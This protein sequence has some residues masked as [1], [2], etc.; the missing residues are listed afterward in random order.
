VVC[1]GNF[2]FVEMK[3]ARF[4][5]ALAMCR[6]EEA[7]MDFLDELLA[8]ELAE[9]DDSAEAIKKSTRRDFDEFDANKDQQL[10]AYEVAGRF[11]GKINPIDLFY[12]FTQADKD[13]SGTVSFPEYEAYV[14]FATG[15]HPE[16]S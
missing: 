15:S 16:E 10:D 3:V 9:A 7:D 1:L 5:L 2:F 13:L 11:G 4:V 14:E 6:A 8:E 12:F